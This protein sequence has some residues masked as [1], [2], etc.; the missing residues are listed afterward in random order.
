MTTSTS[1]L[2]GMARDLPWKALADIPVVAVGG[3]TFAGSV[4]HVLHL[5]HAHGQMGHNAWA[6]AGSVEILAAW[7]GLEIRRRAGASRYFPLLLMVG[8]VVYIIW[9]NYESS[10][11]KTP[12]GITLAVTPPVAFLVIMLVL[13]T[14]HWKRRKPRKAP[15]AASASPPAPKAPKGARVASDRDMVRDEWQTRRGTDLSMTD[16]EIAVR[17]DI[18]RK[19][20]GSARRRWEKALTSVNRG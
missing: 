6:I 19:S 14:R 20:A 5:A 16:D 10:P 17:L 12:V 9:A 4:D 7:L 3:I 11:D 8:A 2:L 13:E 15:V 18:S 1:R